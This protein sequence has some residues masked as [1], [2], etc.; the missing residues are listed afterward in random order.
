[1][2]FSLQKTNDISDIIETV[3]GYHIIK[4]YE[5]IPAQ[6]LE[7]AKVEPD[8]KNYLTQQSIQKDIPQYLHKLQTDAGVEILDEKLK[9]VEVP[10]EGET[11]T[12]AATTNSAK[13]QMK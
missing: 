1:A 10:V 6:K 12:A 9:P 13:P 7:F 4:L 5:K 11:P 3:Y 8:I 2:A